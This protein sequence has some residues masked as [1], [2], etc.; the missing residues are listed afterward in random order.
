[1]DRYDAQGNA[2]AFGEVYISARNQEAS[3]G[4]ESRVSAY[5]A[6]VEAERFLDEAALDT[7]LSEYDTLTELGL[8]GR[9][10]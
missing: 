2:G 7:L 6:V 1:M 8:R 5:E 9:T 3:L 10:K 4:N